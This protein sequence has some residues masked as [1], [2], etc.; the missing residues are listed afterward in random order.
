MA[1]ASTKDA[2]VDGAGFVNFRYGTDI[3]SAEEVIAAVAGKSI[4]IER[5]YIHCVDAIDVTVGEG[6]SAGA[7]TTTFATFE[8]VAT[9]GSPI[10]LTFTRPVKLTAATSFVADA[11]GGGKVT[12]IASGYVK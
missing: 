9:S 5:L 6:E 7:V 4:Y 10:D 1:W 11:T 3:S 12:I 2:D 8:F